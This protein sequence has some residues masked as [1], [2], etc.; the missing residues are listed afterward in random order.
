[1]D[2]Q[3]SSFP[4][5]YLPSFSAIIINSLNL[6]ANCLIVVTLHYEFNSLLYFLTLMIGS[7][8][9]SEKFDFD[10]VELYI[11]FSTRND[12]VL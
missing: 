11:R 10:I 8:P 6:G 12:I 4:S 2:S 3:Q 9:F 5:S 1:M 7:G